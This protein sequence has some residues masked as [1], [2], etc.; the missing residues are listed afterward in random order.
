MYA[1]LIMLRTND[2]R[3]FIVVEGPADV[4]VFDR[5]TN[6]DSCLPVPAYGKDS[7]HACMYRVIEDDF[8]GVFAILDR[9]WLELIPGDLQD[10]RIVHT[11]QYD[12][13]A[14][15]F[16]ADKV[17]EGIASSYCAGSGFR[18]GASDCTEQD[19]RKVCVAL[20]FPIGVLRYISDRDGLGL[21]LRNFPLGE[22]VKRDQLAVDLD[23]L[24]DLCLARTRNATNSKDLLKE[25]LTREFREI[26]TPARYCSGHDLAKAFSILLK[27]RWNVRVGADVVERSARSSLS[28]ERFRDFSIY[29]EAA[30]WFE[31]K[32]EVIWRC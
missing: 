25:N 12:L 31:G 29:S 26:V 5:F 15:I 2:A 17:Y 1:E 4:A 30:R 32:T 7:A 18:V 28:E 24:I 8:G 23:S 16:F 11:D 19:L 3:H 9:D 13:D 10:P 6:I 22:V 27:Y 21:N 14:C 20:A